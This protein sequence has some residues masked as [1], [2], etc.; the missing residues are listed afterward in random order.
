MS[1]HKQRIRLIQAIIAGNPAIYGNPLHP[2]IQREFGE[3]YQVRRVR[4]PQRRHL[5]QVVHSTRALD[6]SL[7]AFVIY[8]QC[9][10]G[11]SLGKYLASLTNH[12]SPTLNS[13]LSPRDRHR[14]Q[15]TI[16]NTR[17]RFMHEA[18]SYP[19]SENDIS[20]L[21]SE[22]HDCLFAVVNL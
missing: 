1:S 21:L 11:N 7:R 5:L 20:T 16:V 3:A 22:M 15:N 17:N 4:N 12:Q 10:S 13:Q 6:S 2:T 18:G 19:A 14:F 8:H 9:L